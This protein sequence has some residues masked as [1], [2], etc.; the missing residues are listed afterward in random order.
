MSVIMQ[1]HHRQGHTLGIG[2]F[3]TIIDTFNFTW[4]P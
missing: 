4:Y 3:S 2:A 1:I